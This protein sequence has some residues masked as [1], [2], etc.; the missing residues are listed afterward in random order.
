[1]QQDELWIGTMLEGRARW[2]AVRTTDTVEEARKRHG[3]SPVAAAAL[4]RAMTGTLI[5]ASSL[6]GDESVTLRILGDG[7]L[8]GVVSVGNAL[9]EVRGYVREPWVELP[10][11]PNGK[12]DVATAVGA[13]ELAVS[14]SLQNGEV[15]TGMVPLVS[16]EVA[17]DLVHYLL[18]SEQIPSAMLLGVLVEKDYHVAGAGGFLMQ[19]LPG[20]KDE[21]I[22]VLEDV[23]GQLKVGI[24]ELA[25]ESRGIDEMLGHLLGELPYQVLE[26][27]SVG[28]SC[29]CSKDRLGDSL[30][31]LG[32]E[33]LED[34]ISD[35]KAEMICHFCNEH[36][37]FS[38]EDLEVL[39]ERAER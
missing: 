6:K 14:R 2:V 24:S 36:Y 18:S 20:A 23:L 33:E 21:D 38:K 1:M 8:Q 9:G 11:K 27:R 4:G 29:T 15:Y 39:R 12:L 37:L 17:E 19:P 28:F 35:G 30:V 5:L 25:A 3:L 26:R 34:L 22:Q 16:G 13:G 32:R 10:L 7:P 31:S